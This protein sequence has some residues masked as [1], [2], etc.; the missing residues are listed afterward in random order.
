MY[1][2]IIF[3]RDGTIN[4]GSHYY[5]TKIEEFTLL[6]NA[7]EGL[8]KLKEQ[9]ASLY[10]FTQQSCINKGAL[11]EDG[12]TEIHAYMHK[13]LDAE[14]F[15][16]ILYCPHIESDNCNCRKPNTG[17]LETLQ[18][19]YNL[20]KENTLVVGDAERDYLSAK[21]MGF[22]FCLVRTGKGKETEEKIGSDVKFVVD[23]ILQLANLL[24]V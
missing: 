8:Y 1:Q 17:M 3:D 10:I 11:T 7:K 2:H 12:L 16:D 24:K 21:A 23:D 18:N 9:G 22:D 20:T 15:D 14:L 19:K 6:D 4:D 5:V 13:L